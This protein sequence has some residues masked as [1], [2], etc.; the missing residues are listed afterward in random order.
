MQGMLA[1]VLSRPPD[2]VT[3]TQ[4]APLRKDLEEIEKLGLQAVTLA[5]TA[6]AQ[7]KDGYLDT[8]F[9]LVEPDKVYQDNLVFLAHDFWGFVER[10][11]QPPMDGSEET[12]RSRRLDSTQQP[13]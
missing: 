11:E 5:G 1:F 6:A 12:R 4:L 8:Y 2:R 10:G 13:Q 3:Y 7:Q 9:T